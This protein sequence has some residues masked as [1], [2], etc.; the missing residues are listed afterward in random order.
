MVFSSCSPVGNLQTKSYLTHIFPYL[1]VFCSYYGYHADYLAI[2]RGD[3]E[4]DICY[5][6]NVPEW[7]NYT[8]SGG[9][10]SAYIG[11]IDDVYYPEEAM[12][13]DE[14]HEET[15]VIIDTGGEYHY[16]CVS[17]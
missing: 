15:F 13:V 17:T 11:N 3:N 7:C 5:S 8:N 6:T 9:G 10:D 1:L 4:T 2:Y 14:I 12:E 16:M